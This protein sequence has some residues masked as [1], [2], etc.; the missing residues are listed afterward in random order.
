[1]LDLMKA[2]KV[3]YLFLGDGEI[4]GNTYDLDPRGFDCEFR[5]VRTSGLQS[6]APRPARCMQEEFEEYAYY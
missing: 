5:G 3:G 6:V 1:M 2:V 4:S